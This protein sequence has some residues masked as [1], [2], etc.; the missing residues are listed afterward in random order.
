MHVSAS[1]VF[2]FY[3]LPESDLIVKIDRKSLTQLAL[4][5]SGSVGKGFVPEKG[6]I[7]FQHAATYFNSRAHFSH[8]LDDLPP[9]AAA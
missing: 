4:N 1:F 2:R 6:T 9:E 8:W 5:I 3:K 7:D